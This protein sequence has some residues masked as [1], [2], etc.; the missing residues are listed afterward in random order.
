M[1]R[2]HDEPERVFKNHVVI[3]E[4]KKLVSIM[5]DMGDQHEFFDVDLT[6][7]V[8]DHLAAYE[9]EPKPWRRD[10]RQV[11]M[12]PWCQARE[13]WLHDWV[14]GEVL[15]P[16]YWINGDY[17]DMRHCNMIDGHKCRYGITFDTEFVYVFDVRDGTKKNI[18][19]VDEGGIEE[20]MS[21]ARKEFAKIM[22]KQML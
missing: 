22:T 11:F 9:Y 20:A 12:F 18:D 1:K 10:S 7:K 2:A 15:K 13:M 19:I 17:H 6:G 3:D 5:M 14:M 8:L 4:R 16:P 21:I